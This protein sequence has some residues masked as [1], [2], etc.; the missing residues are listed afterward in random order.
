[1]TAKVK[2]T[3]HEAAEMAAQGFEIECYA[4][5]QPAA[6]S[7]RKS[8]TNGRKR[9]PAMKGDVL[10]GWSPEG[11]P[12]TKGKYAA[13]WQEIVKNLFQKKAAA[14]Y[15]LDRIV[16]EAR[17]HGVKDARSMVAHL[18]NSYRVLRVVE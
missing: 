13:A 2:V 11:S 17:V 4:I 10:L 15:T 16:S 5:V 6:G 18:V 9:Q 7:P 8:P 12:P 1:M 14:T 3:L